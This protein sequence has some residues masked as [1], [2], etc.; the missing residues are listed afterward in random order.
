MPPLS[1]PLSKVFRNTNKDSLQRLAIRCSALH[2][3]GG[4]WS[5]GSNRSS[6]K[7]NYLEVTSDSA[8][9][10]R[11]ARQLW[12]RWSAP[13]MCYSSI[14]SEERTSWLWSAYN[15]TKS[16]TK[17]NVEFHVWVLLMSS[18]IKVILYFVN[19][20]WKSQCCHFWPALWWGSQNDTRTHVGGIGEV[21]M[22]CA[23]CLLSCPS[24]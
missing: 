18:Y 5:L 11:T 9:S 23:A 14:S 3:D 17:G 24:C 13:S 19:M 16:Q 8:P 20:A 7:A 22:S 4:I 12:G 10:A 2:T 6:N 1:L 15:E 21:S